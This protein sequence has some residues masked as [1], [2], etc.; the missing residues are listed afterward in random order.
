MSVN[1]NSLHKNLLPSYNDKITI[2][3]VMKS[4]LLLQFFLRYWLMTYMS[5]HQQTPRQQYKVHD[6]EAVCVYVVIL[7]L[8]CSYSPT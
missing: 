7:L 4:I 2:V 1:K 6:E 8:L 5:Q 3:V